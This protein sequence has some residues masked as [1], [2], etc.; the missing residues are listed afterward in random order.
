MLNFILIHLFAN[1][2]I[3]EN[4]DAIKISYNDNN[5]NLIKYMVNPIVIIII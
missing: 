4:N 3:F 5:N 2:N 1:I